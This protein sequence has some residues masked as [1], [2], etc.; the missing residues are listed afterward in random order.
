MKRVR[1]GSGVGSTVERTSDRSDICSNDC[2]QTRGF[3]VEVGRV[4]RSGSRVN[5]MIGVSVVF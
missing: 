2:R 5:E 3:T 1:K 4:Q